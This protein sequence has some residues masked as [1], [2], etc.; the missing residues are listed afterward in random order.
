MDPYI[1]LFSPRA[2]FLWLKLYSES[3]AVR[4]L[5]PERH[6]R[7]KPSAPASYRR[8]RA[9]TSLR[10]PPGRPPSCL[11]AHVGREVLGATPD[12]CPHVRVGVIDVDSS[13]LHVGKIST[14]ERHLA[15]HLTVPFTDRRRDVS[16]IGNRR[17]DSPAPG[18]RGGPPSGRAT[19]SRHSAD[20]TRRPVAGSASVRSCEPDLKA[21]SRPLPPVLL[22]HPS[23]LMS[24]GA[25]PGTGREASDLL[26]ADEHHGRR[27][28]RGNG[29][30]PRTRLVEST[31]GRP[32]WYG[33]EICTGRPPHLF[34]VV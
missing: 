19:Q 18:F 25:V 3:R 21:L 23:A 27:R 31:A 13:R 2:D 30:L 17:T 29:L 14:A 8:D 34:A 5:A 28:R 15:Q 26:L 33:N 6:S 9:P 32:P 12:K 4:V 7:V 24:V 16:P 11:F 20:N 22:T 1:R 10:S